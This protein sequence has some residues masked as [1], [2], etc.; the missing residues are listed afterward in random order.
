MVVASTRRGS[1]SGEARVRVRENAMRN[2]FSG[3]D[4]LTL[5]ALGT[6][7]YI[8]CDLLHELAGHGG[9]C[10]ATGGRPAT[11]SSFH[12]QCVGGWQPLICAAGILTNL[13]AG[14]LLWLIL[15]RRRQ[16]SVHARFFLWFAMAYNLFTGWGYL[17]SSS[18]TNSGDWAQAFRALPAVWQWRAAIALAGAAFYVLSVW[19]A[20]IEMRTLIGTSGPKRTWKL[21]M[22]PYFAAGLVACAAAG[23]NSIMPRSEAFGSAISTT[24]GAW[25]FLFVPLCLRLRGL[26]QADLASSRDITR[27]RAWIITGAA[28]AIIFVVALGRGVRF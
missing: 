22:I 28:L 15:R 8:S 20:A 17:V 9:V 11:F 5:A 7:S 21:M 26:H 3:D 14:V 24:L 1:G 12:F 13:T 19:V 4:A 25:G 16:A 27:S 6:V 18:I 2:D 10:I 23:F